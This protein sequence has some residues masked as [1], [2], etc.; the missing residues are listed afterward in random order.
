MVL[1]KTFEMDNAKASRIPVCFHM[2]GYK[3]DENPPHNYKFKRGSSLAAFHRFDI[4][5]G[6]TIVDVTLIEGEDDKLQVTVV[7][8]VNGKGLKFSSGDCQKII[9]EMESVALWVNLA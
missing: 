8:D 4:R 5:R 2:Q 6:P 9:A 1:T 7:Y 3:L